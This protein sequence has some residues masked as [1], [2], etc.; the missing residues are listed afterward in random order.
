MLIA[1]LNLLYTLGLTRP[2]LRT[3]RF[4]ER[5]ALL[6]DR[7]DRRRAMTR[8][9]NQ[10]NT[11]V[12]RTVSFASEPVTVVLRSEEVSLTAD[13]AR[14][15]HEIELCWNQYE[16]ERQIAELWSLYD[17]ECWINN[18][19]DETDAPSAETIPGTLLHLVPQTRPN[20]HLVR[21][22]NTSVPT[23]PPT[24]SPTPTELFPSKDSSIGWDPYFPY[25]RPICPD[26]TMRTSS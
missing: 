8:F 14:I 11:I 22:L 4:L 21:P 20:L 12:P 1:I 2:A 5:H 26:S 17:F 13:Q 10:R 16:T 18:D 6:T 9:I 23:P 7:N 25:L 19:R 24:P 15:A 3:A